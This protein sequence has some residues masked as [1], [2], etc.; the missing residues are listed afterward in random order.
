MKQQGQLGAALAALTESTAEALIWS[1]Q[2]GAND[3]IQGW[4]R[5]R[6]YLAPY[7]GAMPDYTDII[8]SMLL[9]FAPPGG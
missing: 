5:V 4:S 9:V 8:P 7:T 2:P 1:L 6:Q 3:R